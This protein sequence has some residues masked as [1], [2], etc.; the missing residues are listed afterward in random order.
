MSL[1][2]KE[3]KNA[4]ALKRV[5]SVYRA[6][7]IMFALI[8]RQPRARGKLITQNQRFMSRFSRTFFMAYEKL[9][10]PLHNLKQVQLDCLNKNLTFLSLIFSTNTAH[11]L[12]CDFVLE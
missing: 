10:L 4:A 5:G 2:G 7:N 1:V 8:D 11:A 9:P 3:L 6:Y 12:P